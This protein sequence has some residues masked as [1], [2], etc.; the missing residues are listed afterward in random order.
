MSYWKQVK[1]E[2]NK[3]VY[4]E[5]G[6]ISNA[7]TLDAV[8]DLFSQI[9]ALR[10]R[11]P[12]EVEF[13]FMEAFNKD[14]LLAT[15]CAFYARDVRQGLGERKTF[16]IILAWLAKNHPQ[17]VRKNISFIPEYGRWDDLF[18]LIGT[19]V[20]SSMVELIKG[21]LGSDNG[22]D[23]PTLLGKWMPSC[24]TSSKAKRELAK[25][26]M[27]QLNMREKGYRKLLSNLRNKIRIVESQMCRQKW[28]EIPYDKIPSRASMIY[29]KAFGRHDEARYK[30]Y[31]EAVKKG[32]KKINVGNLYPY[33]LCQRA[34][35]EE[36]ETIEVMWKNLPD[37]TGKGES[38]IVVA[39]VSGSMT[40]GYGTSIA[41]IFVSTSIALY[42][43]ERNKGIF[44]N[45]FITFSGTPT[46]IEITG[47]TLKEKY[48]TISHADWGGTTNLLGV[49]ELLLRTA[50]KYKS[51]PEDMPKKIYIISDMEF[52]SGVDRSRTNFEN[53]D[54][55]YA[56]YGYT[57]PQLVFWNVCSR[58]DQ[59]PVTMDDKGTF[60]ISGLTPKIFEAMMKSEA[61]GPMDLMLDILNAERYAKIIA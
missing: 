23:T 13:K 28:G 44:Q 43:A 4:T 34:I 45:K 37:Y 31:L 16:R 8:L 22:S 30:E 25:F 56:D 58:N 1:K 42:F 5:K 52:D 14:P 51:N 60:L 61:I 19:Q 27:K 6:A 18:V 40:S 29:R 49:F 50:V 38:A 57:R 54:G 48:E 39:D 3:S 2:S 9:G 55:M 46:L 10:T 11:D 24:N 47:T 41:P 7:S 12:S 15:K 17:V 53:I 59:Q 32:E 26:F 20:E 21:Q 35:R 33:E 36:D